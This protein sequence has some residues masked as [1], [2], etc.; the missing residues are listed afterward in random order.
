MFT[1]NVPT[2]SLHPFHHMYNTYFWSDLLPRSGST[3]KV[4]LLWL[5]NCPCGVRT[6]S[7]YQE[8]T[9]LSF[10]RSL[11]SLFMKMCSFEVVPPAMT[12]GTVFILWIIECH[13]VLKDFLMHLPQAYLVFSMVLL[14]PYSRKLLVSSPSLHVIMCPLQLLSFWTLA[15]V[16]FFKRFLETVFY[17]CPQV[18]AFSI[19]HSQ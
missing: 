3:G 13:P 16:L 1:A 15:I 7:P 10:N 9:V 4:V 6:Y 8:N 19:G 5:L 14:V 12:T 17:L 2:L 11:N 18:E